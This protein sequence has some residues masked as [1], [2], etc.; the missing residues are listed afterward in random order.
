MHAAHRFILFVKIVFF[1]CI[2]GNKSEENLFDEINRQRKNFGLSNVEI[3]LTLQLAAEKRC[4]NQQQLIDS[5]QRM[6]SNAYR[7]GD[8]PRQ[9]HLDKVFSHG[10]ILFNLSSL[11]FLFF[12]SN[13][14]VNERIYLNGIDIRND[15]FQRYHLIP[16]L[17]ERNLIYIGIALHEYRNFSATC[18][19]YGELNNSISNNSRLIRLLYILIGCG[20]LLLGLIVCSI[21]NDQRQMKLKQ[22]LEQ[23]IIGNRNTIVPKNSTAVFI[24]KDRKSSTHRADMNRMT[25]ARLGSVVDERSS[26]VHSFVA[27]T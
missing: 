21:V 26:A 19:V 4:H 2:F 6:L 23:E 10:K 20:I 22:Q 13:F 14:I 12:S 18:I 8:W 5:Y 11:P 3:H 24:D 25:M 15:I 1:S 17:Y 16:K 9:E 27:K 7:D